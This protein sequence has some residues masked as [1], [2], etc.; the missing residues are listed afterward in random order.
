MKFRLDKV[1]N[2]EVRIPF[3]HKFHGTSE[4]LKSIRLALE[5]TSLIQQK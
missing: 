3:S 2:T 5:T 1:M 4:T